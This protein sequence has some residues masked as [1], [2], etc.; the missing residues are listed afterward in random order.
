MYFT[1]FFQHQKNC[2]GRKRHVSHT[3]MS[4][5]VFLRE[6]SAGGAVPG[7]EGPMQAEGL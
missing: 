6:H 4:L 2:E 3:L 5:F 1:Q 7:D